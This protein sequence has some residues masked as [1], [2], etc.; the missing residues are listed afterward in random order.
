MIKRISRCGYFPEQSEDPALTEWNTIQKNAKTWAGRLILLFILKCAMDKYGESHLF[1]GI[2]AL[3][4]KPLTSSWTQKHDLHLLIGVHRHG[5]NNFRA[6]L[7]D[8]NLMFYGNFR[9][10]ASSAAQEKDEDDIGTE[11]PA[12]SIVPSGPVDLS[13]EIWPSVLALGGRFKRLMDQLKARD[14]FISEP[15]IGASSG[16]S[17]PAKKKAKTERGAI[18]TEELDAV[19]AA[20]KEEQ[21][22]RKLQQQRDRRERLRLEKEAAARASVNPTIDSTLTS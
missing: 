22:L 7:D 4:G 6:I 21:R 12:P 19:Q 17:A 13:M 14:D 5:F 18:I 20:K 3:T 16:S 8:P 10:D 15:A 11:A 2:S 1:D 9:E